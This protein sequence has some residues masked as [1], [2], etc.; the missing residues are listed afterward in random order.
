MIGQNEGTRDRE[1]NN[2]QVKQRKP[3]KVEKKT[4]PYIQSK[5]KQYTH[6]THINTVTSRVRHNEDNTI[7]THR[8]TNRSIDHT[9]T[10]GVQ[11]KT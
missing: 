1:T 11:F 10:S 2:N 8:H 5:D 9:E 6:H 3:N 7:T 4:K